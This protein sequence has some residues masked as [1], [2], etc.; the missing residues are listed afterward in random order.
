[1]STAVL[2]PAENAAPS[3]EA[4]GDGELRVF[5]NIIATTGRTPLIRLNHIARDAGA[6][7]LLKGDKTAGTKDTMLVPPTPVVA[8]NEAEAR[9]SAARAIPETNAGDLEQITLLVRPF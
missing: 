4:F 6:A 8:K 7:I 9:I 2:S 3:S 5:P 1:M